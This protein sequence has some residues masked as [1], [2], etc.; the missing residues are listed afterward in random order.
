MEIWKDIIG[1]EGQY[2]ISSHGRVK[3]LER[4]IR[5]GSYGTR[6]LPEKIM[7]TKPDKD[8]YPTIVLY[9]DSKAKTGFVHRLVAKH[10]ISNPNDLPVVNHKDETKDNN[11]VENLE[12]CTVQYNT[13]YGAGIERR[14]KKQGHPVAQYTLDG[15]LVDTYESLSDAGR[16][17]GRKY[18]HIL[19][20][21]QRNGT[22]GGFRWEYI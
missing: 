1:Y 22:C 20:S 21:I 18:N 2:Q 17:V 13:N 4:T 19:R 7:K 16:T 15:V 12:W 10:F 3:S 11:C 6:V 8:G 9:K 5:C 14:V